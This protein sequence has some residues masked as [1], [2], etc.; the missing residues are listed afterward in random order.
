ML[1]RGVK[2]LVKRLGNQRKNHFGQSEQ[3][4]LCR[5]PSWKRDLQVWKTE[6]RLDGEEL[7]EGERRT[8]SG[9]EAS[10]L[11]I[12]TFNSF[13]LLLFYL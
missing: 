12:L 13:L 7:S 1:K 8:K 4:S 10:G 2:A 6:R 3:H 9:W 11:E 5:A